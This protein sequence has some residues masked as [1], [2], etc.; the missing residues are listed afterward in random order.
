MDGN[1]AMPRS[2]LEFRQM[3]ARVL[4]SAGRSLELA[5]TAR[6]ITRSDDGYVAVIAPRDEPAGQTPSL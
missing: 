1:A 6:L 3:R 5:R 2:R 4:R